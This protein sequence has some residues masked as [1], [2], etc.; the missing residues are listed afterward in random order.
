MMKLLDHVRSMSVSDAIN[1]VVALGTLAAALFAA[2]SARYAARQMELS[3]EALRGQTFVS[4]LG[5]ERETNFSRKMDVIRSVRGK[6]Y[7]QLTNEEKDAIRV[8]VDFLNHIAHLIKYGYVS[9]EHMLFLYNASIND[10]E[11]VLV[12]QVKWLDGLRKEAE[13][14]ILYLHFESLCDK[15]KRAMIWAGRAAEVAWTGDHFKP[16]KI[17]HS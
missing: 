12:R 5:Y 4:V 3:R 16:S 13:N 15:K 14:Q 9:G 8:A 2:F 1:S 7:A 10:C 11:D 6:T 17:L